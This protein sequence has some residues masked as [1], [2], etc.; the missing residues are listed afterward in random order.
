MS[1][2]PAPITT[3]TPTPVSTP[4]V[5]TPTPGPISTF[6]KAHERLIILALVLAVGVHFYGKVAQAWLEHEQTVVTVSHDTLQAQVQQNSVS[7][8]QTLDALKQYEQLAGQLATA[9]AQF[10]QNQVQR[11][12]QTVVQQNADQ[13]MSPSDL[14][15]R[16]TSLLNLSPDE[17]AASGSGLL[18]TLPAAQATAQQLEEVPTL[19]ANLKDQT[20]AS[21]NL[22]QQLDSLSTVNGDQQGQ[23]IGL[24]KQLVDQ[25]AA[26]VADKKVLQTQVKRSFWRGFKY[27]FVTGAGATA[28]AVIAFLK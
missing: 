2:T 3:A 23:I 27:G 28:A 11:N 1:I 18:S 13:Q 10:V 14:A 25:A 22:Q 26:C 4:A 17:I 19:Q 6:L 20:Q 12:K 21:T 15:Q 5:Q 7:N 8:Q 24:N 16:L 9:N